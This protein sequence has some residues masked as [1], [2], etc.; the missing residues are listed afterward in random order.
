MWVIR[1]SNMGKMGWCG[2]GVVIRGEWAGVGYK[3]V[4]HGENG[5]VWSGGC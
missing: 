4:K 2:V 1:E 5:L 3:G